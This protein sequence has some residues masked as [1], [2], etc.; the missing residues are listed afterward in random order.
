MNNIGL[1]GL[2]LRRGI[3]CDP[4][5][6]ELY[7]ALAEHEI[8]RGKYGCVSFFLHLYAFVIIIPIAM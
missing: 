4:S 5:N 1:V 2:I 8:S 6:T 7:R 3:E